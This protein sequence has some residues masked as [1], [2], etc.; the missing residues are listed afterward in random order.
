M[1]EK[2][3]SLEQSLAE[4]E[5]LKQQLKLENDSL[6]EAKHL[7]WDQLI[8]EFKKLKY[9]SV[10]VEYE[11]E[12]ANLAIFQ[13]SM[14]DRPLKACHAIFYLISRTK[15]QLPFVGIQDRV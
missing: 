7:I 9:Y 10:E 6:M 5:F 11:R 13:Q 15:P 14:G 12:L 1:Q 3:K 8:Y 2:Y 4:K